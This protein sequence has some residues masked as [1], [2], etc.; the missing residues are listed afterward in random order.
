M[1]WT[2]FEAQPPWVGGSPRFRATVTWDSDL[3][4]LTGYKSLNQGSLINTEAAVDKRREKRR[5]QIFVAS[6]LSPRSS[7][8]PHP[9]EKKNW[10]EVHRKFYPNDQIWGEGRCGNHGD[11]AQ[12]GDNP[13]LRA[14]RIS[15]SRLSCEWP[16]IPQTLL[17]RVTAQMAET[18]SVLFLCLGNIVRSTMSEIST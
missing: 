13:R 14:P 9:G 17:H 16:L 6:A 10:E 3:Y 5:S 7:S 1:I 18:H 2:R 11:C 12:M 8:A 15:S 4:P